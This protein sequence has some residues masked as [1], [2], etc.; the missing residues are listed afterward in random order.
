MGVEIG[1]SSPMRAITAGMSRFMHGTSP[2]GTPK[3]TK[4]AG[5][6]TWI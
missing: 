5:L 4:P 2:T 6:C 3:L 1:R